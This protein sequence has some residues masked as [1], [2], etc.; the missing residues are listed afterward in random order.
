MML[1]VV[2][3]VQ[4]KQPF[5]GPLTLKIGEQTH[6]VGRELAGHVFAEVCRE[7]AS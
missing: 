5:N 1:A 4:D 2:V 7:E 3:E 6:S